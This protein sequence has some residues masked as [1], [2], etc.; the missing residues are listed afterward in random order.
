VNFAQKTTTR[1]LTGPVITIIAGAEGE[2]MTIHADLLLSCDSRSLRV[3]VSGDWKES[4]ERVI[5]W[6][7]EDAATI[8]R[9]LTFLYMGD[10]SV[11]DPEPVQKDT[12]SNTPITVKGEVNQPDE[13][14][15]TG[16]APSADIIF[17]FAAD[18]PAD[19]PPYSL[20]EHVG[21][22]W[23]PE[24]T[25]LVQ[26]AI[27]ESLES[28]P[29]TPVSRCIDIGLPAESIQTA[30]GRLE[31]CLFGSKNHLYGATFL[32]HARV[33]TFAQYH[34]VTRLENFALQRLMQALMYLDCT[35]PHA[36]SEILPLIEYAYENTVRRVS[37]RASSKATLA[38]RRNPLH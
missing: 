28:R 24:E 21:G 36:V 37:R 5:D 23:P 12:V 26:N 15:A 33:Y 6:S 34:L 38:I 1:C 22:E 8:E 20:P 10:Y 14:I 4:R 7:K 32:A 25:P 13:N 29:L 31:K 9:F 2:L 18:A 16:A 3:L 35:Q 30:A 11:P 27:I 17:E 19:A